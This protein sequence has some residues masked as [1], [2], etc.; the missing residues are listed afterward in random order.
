MV[1]NQG[2]ETGARLYPIKLKP[3]QISP[4]VG[5][6]FRH[7]RFFQESENSGYG[8]G[9]PSY[10]RFIHPLQFGLS[11][12]SDKW[13]ISASGYYNYQNNFDYNITPDRSAS[14]DLNQFSL[15]FS[16][17]KYIDSDRYMRT[18]RAVRKINNDYEIL[19]D[20][21]LLSSWFFAVGPSSALQLSKSPY[22]KENFS[23]FY[24]DFTAS[25]LPDIA[26]GRYFYKPDM[27]VNLSYRIYGNNYE[28][29]D[30]FISTRRHSVGVESVKF[31]FNWLGFVPFA[32][33]AVTYANLRTSVNGVDYN[34]GKAALGF[35]FGWDIRVTQTGSSILRTNL[36]YFPNL[37]MN[38]EGEKMM[39]DHLE[40]NFIQYVHFIGRK[41][42]LRR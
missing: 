21:E 24:D 7:I 26:F 39:F 2:V 37:H 13:P 40:F 33:A 29:F 36:R 42:T 11:Y 23:F 31:L 1:V 20:K 6:S 16:F 4:F 8:S 17:L 15:N 18:K 10:G 9:V 27:N 41:I 12:T 5:M 14:V 3:G 38:I 28:G 25:I 22:L 30:N 34:E 32:G 19:K 35:V